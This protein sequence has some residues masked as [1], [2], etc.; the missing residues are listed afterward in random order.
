MSIQVFRKVGSF[1]PGDRGIPGRAV[2][3]S[4][5]SSKCEHNFSRVGT[6]ISYFLKASIYP[7]F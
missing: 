2:T 6:L 5:N 7:G 4:G 1:G 3:R